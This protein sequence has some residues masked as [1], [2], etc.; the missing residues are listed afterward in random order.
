MACCIAL[1]KHSVFSVMNVKTAH[2]GYPKDD[3]MEHV[4]EIKGNTAEAKAQRAE[5]RGKHVCFRQDF[6]VEGN[7]SVTIQAAG[8][9]KKVPLLLVASHSSMLAGEEHTK[10]WHNNLADG[11]T[12]YYKKVTAQP[13]MHA[14]YRR[15]MNS[16]D[17]HNKLR[18]GVVSMADVWQTT[19][20]VE[21]HFAEGLGM[22]EVN[23]YKA[24]QYFQ[25]NKWSG[26]SHSEFRSRLAF[27]LMTLGKAKFP[28]DLAAGT[29]GFASPPNTTTCPP[30]SPLPGD[31]DSM[32]AG[33]GRHEWVICEPKICTYCGKQT[34]RT[35]Q[36]CYESDYGRFFAC[37]P[38]T[39]RVCM[40][41]HVRG[42][43]PRHTTW[44]MSASG[45]EKLKKRKASS[46]S[47]SESEASGTD[48]SHT[49]SRESPN[50]IA[51]RTARAQQTSSSRD[52]VRGPAGPSP[53]SSSS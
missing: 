14:L 11:T 43:P 51:R 19:S 6:A 27:S 47:E 12:Q 46:A 22:W 38:G 4:Q 39:G 30:P 9:N 7:R 53:A 28:S 37:Q 18:Q 3:I 33:C 40:A 29:A 1:F 5:R 50:S 48:N 16:V 49:G 21:R 41:E 42:V 35:C 52:P 36:T 15:H 34:R 31:D 24:L 23:V 17:I 13:Q 45:K 44:S 25:P 32:S 26:I 2:R 8:H 10:V 20:W